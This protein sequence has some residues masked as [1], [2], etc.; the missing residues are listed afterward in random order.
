PAAFVAALLKLLQPSPQSQWIAWIPSPRPV[1][2]E[3]REVRLLRIGK[4]VDQAEGRTVGGT[5]VLAFG[6]LALAVPGESLVDLDAAGAIPAFGLR[7]DPTI[8]S[9][10]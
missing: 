9:T 7:N 3:L 6:N 8:G 4:Q 5:A 2:G 10:L 1:S